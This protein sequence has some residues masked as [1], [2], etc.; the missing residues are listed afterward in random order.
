[1][2]FNK[3]L[4]KIWN[5]IKKKFLNKKNSVKEKVKKVKQTIKNN[6]NS[7]VEFLKNIDLMQVGKDIIQ[8][9]IDGIGSMARAAKNKAKEI[10]GGITG[11]I[12]NL[13]K[14]S[15]PSK[16]LAEIGRWTAKV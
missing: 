15:S 9:L 16:V 14:I 5:K 10:A 13:L 1:K 7:A 12:K 6:W 11:G 4:N 8:G 2:F 3:N